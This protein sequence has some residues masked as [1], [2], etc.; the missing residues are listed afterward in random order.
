MKSS[1]NGPPPKNLE[2]EAVLNAVDL[3]KKFLVIFWGPREAQIVYRQH[4]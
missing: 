2:L 3:A 4:S 1:R